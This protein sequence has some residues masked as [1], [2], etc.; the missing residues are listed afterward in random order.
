MLQFGVLGTLPCS[1]TMASRVSRSN[2]LAHMFS[3]GCLVGSELL[4]EPETQPEP[5]LLDLDDLI[6]TSQSLRQLI[7]APLTM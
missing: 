2:P 7:R 4:T 6:W 5:N 1:W 3:R